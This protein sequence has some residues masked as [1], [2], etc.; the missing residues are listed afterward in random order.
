MGG[1]KYD[2]NEDRS[3]FEMSRYGEFKNLEREDYLF[4]KRINMSITL[5][6]GIE[7]KRVDRELK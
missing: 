3:D 2:T 1:L 5:F 7:V 4:A 6:I